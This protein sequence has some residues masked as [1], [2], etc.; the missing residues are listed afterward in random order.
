MKKNIKVEENR[1][2]VTIRVEDLLAGK[3]FKQLTS[4]AD[5]VAGYYI[6]TF[7]KRL[8]N[9]YR[10]YD[11]MTAVEDT[12]EFLEYMQTLEL[13]AS[14]PPEMFTPEERVM[15]LRK[16]NDSLARRMGPQETS[17]KVWLEEV[18]S[19]DDVIKDVYTFSM[20]LDRLPK[21][22]IA[23]EK[24]EFR[25]HI[26]DLERE[27]KKLL[28]YSNVHGSQ[29]YSLA[30]N[31]DVFFKK[32]KQVMTILES[33]NKK[34]YSVE[35]VLDYDGSKIETI[36]FE[37][38]EPYALNEK[39]IKKLEDLNRKKLVEDIYFSEFF[40]E[41][42]FPLNRDDIWSY[43][44]VIIANSRILDFA[45]R[46]R[47]EGLSPLEK[48]YLV[49]RYFQR[50]KYMGVASAD[51]K[52]R[53]FITFYDARFPEREE[54]MRAENEAFICTSFASGAKTAIDAIGDEN[55]KAFAICLNMYMR[56]THRIDD[57][58]HTALVVW[59][60]DKKYGKQG[61]YMYDPTWSLKSLEAVLVPVSDYDMLRTRFLDV[62]DEQSR[63]TNYLKTPRSDTKTPEEA[64]NVLTE[65]YGGKASPISLNETYSIL[66]N[67]YKK[68]ALSKHYY[69]YEIR[70][71]NPQK[72][73]KKH[74]DEAFT[75]RVL[76]TPNARNGYYQ[77]LR[78]YFKKNPDK[79]PDWEQNWAQ[80]MKESEFTPNL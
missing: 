77:Y 68:L 56:D 75:N 54:A 20:V 11:K 14:K 28:S 25:R 30:I 26:E 19:E 12:P 55:L 36:G 67:L 65:K 22:L 79:F 71:N 4:V 69:D 15:L 38:R 42:F 62:S 49:N 24:I 44:E 57:P 5:D 27:M 10:E 74:I 59:L 18:Y 33:I 16:Y 63:I 51:E 9:M 34:G 61:Y 37:N 35:L 52:R 66:V 23:P 29:T 60:N 50:S 2:S 40:E 7:R 73:A 78:D 48:V 43:D 31:R 39:E 41:R 32:Y 13:V 8:S 1:R 6:E 58:A 64:R 76:Y 46:V 53:T 70:T 47:E 3:S 17:H 72:L 45:G 80:Y 21:T